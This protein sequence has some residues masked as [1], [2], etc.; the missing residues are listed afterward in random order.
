MCIRAREAVGSVNIPGAGTTGEFTPCVIAGTYQFPLSPFAGTFPRLTAIS[1]A[2]EFYIFKRVQL[3][4]IANRSTSSDGQAM[5]WIDYE[6]SDTLAGDTVSAL[7]N[8]SSVIS[9]IY[10]CQTLVGLKSLS[11][12]DKYVTNSTADVNVNQSTQA[13]IS[14][15]VEGFT[16]IANLSIGQ[17][18]IEYEIEFFTP[19][20]VLGVYLRHDDIERMA[21]L[22]L[23]VKE[24]ARSGYV[25]TAMD[26]L[27][28]SFSKRHHK[29]EPKVKVLRDIEEVPEKGLCPK[30]T[31][32]P[33]Q[34]TLGKNLR[35][36]ELP[37]GYRST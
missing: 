29:R 20:Q 5:F 17:A 7:A 15:A 9:N 30:D 28:D 6:T 8:I 16:G 14:G 27:I 19:S 2:Y 1:A 13:Y 26:L 21:K 36:V 33:Q 37:S 4:F 31:S 12:M 18:M 3:D 10:A 22:C 34:T 23:D 25:D 24:V 11:R 32:V 35:I